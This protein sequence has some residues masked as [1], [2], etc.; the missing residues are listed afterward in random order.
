ME[1]SQF[2][3]KYRPKYQSLNSWYSDYVK[4]E[5][6]IDYQSE[7]SILKSSDSAQ[8]PF[9]N[10]T[11][12]EILITSYNSGTQTYTCT[13]ASWKTNQYRY[14][15]ILDN[16]NNRYKIKSNTSN[17]ITLIPSTEFEYP[18]DP[19]A[20]DSLKITL[21]MFDIG[22]EVDL[23]AFKIAND[24][25]YVDVTDDD[26]IFVGQVKS[27]VDNYNDNSI[28]TMIKLENIT[29]VLFKSFNNPK[30]SYDGSFG[31]FI[32]KIE[33]YIISWVQQTNQNMITIEWDVDNPTLKR[34]GVT[35]FPA[36]DY[37]TDYKSNYEIIYDL[38]Q[39][40]YTQDGEYYFYVKPKIS[41]GTSQPTY[42][43]VLRPKLQTTSTSLVEGVDFKLVSRIKDKGDIVSFL[44]IRC[45]RDMY[46]KNIT[47]YVIG[48]LK[49]GHIGKPIALNFA[50]DIMSY[51]KAKNTA[52]FDD[53]T[54]VGNPVPFMPTSLKASTG[55]Y[56]TAYLVTAQEAA[57][58]PS[59]L[60][61][62]A[63]TATTEAEYKDWVRWLARAK[64]QIAGMQYILQNNNIKNK[65]SII[66][67]NTPTNAIPGTLDNLTINSIGWTSPNSGGFNY[68]KKVRQ[69]NRTINISKKGIVTIVAYEE[70][71]EL[72]E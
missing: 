68:T 65:V 69:T 6:Y 64:A 44:I 33:D 25:A 38:C 48:N 56:T 46:N 8:L 57:I 18:G 37:F 51:E 43:F 49:H 61:V 26:I 21:P 10:K 54:P 15:T 17:T 20:A 3:I 67:Y 24:E 30:L 4:L 7:E 35:A 66:F 53:T 59:K 1:H 12:D 16:L 31:T 41:T 32:E 14:F 27:I 45:G 39:D 11:F 28:T 2:V 5:S 23:Y 72:S 58:Y 40:K 19:S 62:G 29:E 55:N 36:M 42:V 34:D 47:T 50:G 52:S 22:D 9:I 60:S 63:L 70:D 13:G 71:W